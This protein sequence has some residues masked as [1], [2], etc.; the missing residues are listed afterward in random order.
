M[1]SRR[2]WDPVQRHERKIEPGDGVRLIRTQ[3]RVGYRFAEDAP[4]LE[5]IRHLRA[6]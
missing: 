5:P 2:P 6:A 1:R 4:Q 3:H